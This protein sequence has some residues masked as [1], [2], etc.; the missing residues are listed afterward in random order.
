M[1]R[2]V[3]N[4]KWKTEIATDTIEAR[5]QNIFTKHNIQIGENGPGKITGFQGSQTI[6]ENL[7]GWFVN[8]AKL[9]KKLTIQWLALGN[10]VEI[11]VKLEERLEGDFEDQYE[12]RYADFF[13]EWIHLLKTELVHI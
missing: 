8:P 5:I 7:G 1:T 3:L 4:H 11:L 2:L 6:T 9:P 10:E 13:E 12:K